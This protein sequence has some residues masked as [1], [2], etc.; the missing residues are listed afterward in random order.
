[1]EPK[2][3]IVWIESTNLAGPCA[4]WGFPTL[5][6]FFSSKSV[7]KNQH[8]LTL[9]FIFE[10]LIACFSSSVEPAS[11]SCSFGAKFG[12]VFLTKSESQNL[13]NIINALATKKMEQRCASHQG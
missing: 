6:E 5:V 4:D 8:L 12:L 1:L 13:S 3:L 9:S 11:M 7:F 2:F 10:F